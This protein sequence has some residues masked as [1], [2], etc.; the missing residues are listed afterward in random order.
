M[1][2]TTEQERTAAAIRYAEEQI[3]DL[4]SAV[5]LC[6]YAEDVDGNLVY[7][8]GSYP[9]EKRELSAQLR[10]WEK[11]LSLLTGNLPFGFI[12]L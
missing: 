4:Q 6:D 1:R 10:D 5:R 8:P 3:R 7:E 12:D 9:E 11:L 2:I